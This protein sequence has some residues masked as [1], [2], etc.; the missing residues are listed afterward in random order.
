MNKLDYQPL[1]VLIRAESSDS[2]RGSN[3]AKLLRVAAVLGS[4]FA[5]AGVAGVCLIGL[6]VYAP[7]TSSSKESAA[8]PA[9][10]TKN[11]SP[12]APAGQ[13]SDVRGLP[14]DAIQ[15]DREATAT[16]ES[17]AAQAPTPVPDPTA[18]PAT[19]APVESKEPVT[20]RAVPEGAH[21]EIGRK[22]LEKERRRAE[23]K[24]SQLEE[25]YEKHAITSEAYKEGEKKYQI[26]IERYRA[27]MNAAKGP[28]NESGF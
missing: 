3:S 19:P 11:V 27:D 7:G 28:K 6:G 15:S 24:R 9:L 14:V 25:S 12:P 20:G 13:E 26:E 8:I 4:L 22:N 17:T 5:L 2:G 23:L 21:R 1:P 16:D 18:V 10:P